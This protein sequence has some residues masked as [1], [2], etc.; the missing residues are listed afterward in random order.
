MPC[1]TIADNDWA[2]VGAGIT[3]GDEVVKYETKEVRAIRGTEPLSVSKWEK[4]GWELVGQAQ[5]TLSSTLTFRR[6]KPKP[7]WLLIG[8]AAALAVVIG[9]GT[10]VEAANGGGSH[11]PTSNSTPTARS[12]PTQASSS[13]T[14]A[15][16]SPSQAPAASTDTLTKGGALVFLADAW[17][18]RFKYGGKVHY[19]DDSSAVR[20]PNGSYIITMGADVKNAFGA[21]EHA[22]IRGIVAGT[23]SHPR[24]VSST[25][26]LGGQTYDY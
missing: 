13:P 26:D 15:S 22:T 23:E 24:I 18:S 1:E 3:V 16:A 14:S 10:A 8:G 7:P 25:M 2:G 19:L 17:K 20:N 6:P 4:E 11:P 9:V 21:S 12:S 5:G